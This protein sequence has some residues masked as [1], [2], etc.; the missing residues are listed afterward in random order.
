MV[1]RVHVVH[2]VWE[3][4]KQVCVDGIITHETGDVSRDYPTGLH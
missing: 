3:E 1:Q 4:M 2:C